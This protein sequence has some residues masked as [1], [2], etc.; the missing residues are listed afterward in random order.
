MKNKINNNEFE[1]GDIVKTDRL[2]SFIDKQRYPTLAIILSKECLNSSNNDSCYKIY[3]FDNGYI[4]D[5]YK[6]YLEK[7]KENK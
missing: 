6:F 7:I 1:I 3:L 2:I 4:T 5:C